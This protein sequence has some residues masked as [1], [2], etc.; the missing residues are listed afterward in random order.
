[1]GS[2]APQVGDA[3]LC[4]VSMKDVLATVGLRAA[5]AGLQ[6]FVRSVW[7][8]VE[9]FPAMDAFHKTVSLEPRV[10]LETYTKKVNDKPTAAVL[11]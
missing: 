6:G 1:M 5:R 4:R 11:E 2:R 7:R 8:F 10:T 9:R 3:V